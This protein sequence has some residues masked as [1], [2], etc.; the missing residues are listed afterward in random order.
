MDLIII[1]G[2]LGS[3]KTTFIN[4]LL[5]GL[6]ERPAVLE[7]E[8]GDVSI[9]SQLIKADNI[10]EINSGCICCSLKDDFKREIENIKSMDYGLC[11]I[12]PTGLA[13]LSDVFN[14]VGQ[15][16]EVKLLNAVTIVDCDSYLLFHEDFGPFFNDQIKNA[17]IIYITD[18]EK[19]GKESIYKVYQMLKEQNSDAFIIKE[20]FLDIAREEILDLI[21]TERRKD[22]SKDC[23][24]ESHH[25][26][27]DH[28]HEAKNDH[29]HHHDDEPKTRTEKF[30]KFENLDQALKYFSDDNFIRAK[31]KIYVGEKSYL[32]SKTPAS[33]K[34]DD[35]DG[36]DFS[37]D[38]VIIEK[39]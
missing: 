19:L 32:V 25:H 24:E 3:G 4:H 36:Q 5:G 13:K 12:E 10:I 31:G 23:H 18:I 11:L 17:D 28:H 39:K 30:L 8:F 34:I 6:D 9:D 35:L 26:E 15:I 22:N 37:D 16:D 20:N 38:L 33:V 7:N 29:D 21:K 1:S 14:V 2:F 27:E